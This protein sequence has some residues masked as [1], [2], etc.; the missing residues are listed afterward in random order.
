MSSTH[1]RKI[2][3]C[4]KWA[5]SGF[6]LQNV[7]STQSGGSIGE[8]MKT[9]S[10]T[11]RCN[12]VTDYE[13][14]QWKCPLYPILHWSYLRPGKSSFNREPRGRKYQHDDD[15]VVIWTRRFVREERKTSYVRVESERGRSLGLTE[16]GERERGGGDDPLELSMVEIFMMENGGIHNNWRNGEMTIMLRAGEK[17]KLSLPSRIRMVKEMVGASKRWRGKGSVGEVERLSS[18]YH[19]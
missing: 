4:K 8:R 19:S 17:R 7:L 18:N 11:L 16:T 6:S 13:E 10:L 5:R 1:W 9:G 3:V 14:K 15:V 2:A 12:N